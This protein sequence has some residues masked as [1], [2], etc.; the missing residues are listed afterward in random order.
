MHNKI[1]NNTLIDN[2]ED[3]DIIMPMWNLLEYSDNYSMTLGSLWN[4][5]RDEVK[6]FADKTDNKII[7]W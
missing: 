4:C 5:Y 2:A 1:F 3:L 6:Y 7:M